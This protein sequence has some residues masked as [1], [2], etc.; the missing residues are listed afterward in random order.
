MRA[1]EPRLLLDAASAETAL[2]VAG[3]AAHEQL[4]DDYIANG[5]PVAATVQQQAER[6]RL[7]MPPNVVEQHAV[8]REAEM[9]ALDKRGNEIVFIDSAVDDIDGL[10]A[11]LEPGASVHILDGNS[12]GL[13]QIAEI[14]AGGGQYDAIHIFSHGDPGALQLGNTIVNAT[15]MV[16]EHADTLSS[17]GQAISENAD[18]L[19]YGCRFGEG[20]LG[21]AAADQLALATGADIA[22]SDDLTGSESLSGDWDLEVH[23]GDVQA[24]SYTLPDWE[25]ILPGFNLGA[26]VEPTY[27]HASGGVVGTAGTIAVW[28]GA[29]TRDPGGGNPIEV[30]DVRAI[31]V[32]TTDKATAT[33]ENV[34]SGDGSL[35]DFRVVVT[36]LGDVTGNVGG[37]DILEEQSVT[38][39]WEVIDSL[40]GNPAPPDM[41]NIVLR[42]IDGLAGQPDTRNQVGIAADSL[43]SYTTESTTDLQISVEDGELIAAGT[44][45]GTNAPNSQ[46]GASWAS[47]N[48]FVVTYTTFEQTANIDLD[49]DGGATFADPV[50]VASQ[51]LDLNGAAAGVNYVTTYYNRAIA[52][53]D[54]DVPVSIAD[55]DISIFDLNNNELTESTITLTNAQPGDVL[56]YDIGVLNALG[57]TATYTDNV[58]NI[59]LQLS[60]FASLDNYE[61]AIRSI[62]Y[63]NGLPDGTGAGTI[64]SGID[65]I[66]SVDI[67]DNFISTTGVQ[68]RIVITDASGAPVTGNNIFVEDE[69][70]VLM[71]NAANGLLS[72]DSDPEGTTLTIL[73]AED[74][75]GDP[76][77]LNTAYT[78]PSGSMLTLAADGSFTYVP[79]THYSGNET[80]RYTV[81][82][83]SNTTEGFATF[84]IQPVA[85]NVTLNI[86]QS[87]PTSD[88]DQ[89]TNPIQVGAF[90]PDSG[91]TQEITVEDIP[92]GVVLTDGVNQHESS[93]LFDFVDVTSWNLNNLH[94]LP[95]QNRDADISVTVIA[96]TIESDGSTSDDI[97]TVTFEID[98]VAD[99]PT[100]IVL[101]G[102][103]GVDDDVALFNL[104]SP[105]LFD[106]DGSEQ[107]T[108]ITISNIPAGGQILVSGTPRT[109][110]GGAVSLQ[111]S[112]LFTAVF[113]PPQTGMA[114][115]YNMLVSATATEVAPEGG[116]NISVLSATE[117][118]IGLRVDLN[119]DDDPVVAVD[120]FATTFSGNTISIDVVANDFAPDGGTLITHING[121]PID[122]PTPYTLP[123]GQGVIRLG[124]SGDLLYEASAAFS[125]TFDFTYTVQDTD[126]DA[127]DGLVTVTVLPRWEI[128]NVPAAQEGGNAEFTVTLQGGLAPGSGAD[129]DIGVQ[130]GTASAADIGSL[131]AAINNAIAQPGNEGFSFD[132]TTL[133]YLA[134][135]MSYSSTYEA[136]GSTFADITG[137]A[138]SLNLGGDGLAS[139]DIP[140]SFDFYGGSFDE[141]YVSANGYITFG[142]PVSEP[143]NQ[144]LDGT[145]LT[146]RSIIAPF[147]DDL[148]TTIGDVYVQS[149]GL[150]VSNRQFIIQW[151]MV[152]NESDGSGVGRFQVVLDE[153]TGSVRFNYADVIFD[154]IGDEGA[155][156]TIGL[157]GDGF[158]DQFS[159][160]QAGSVVDGSSIVF[161]RGVAINPSLTIQLP[162]IDDPAFEPQETFSLV[163]SNPNNAGL[164]ADTANTTID[165][166]DNSPPDAIDD[167]TAVLETSTVSLNVITAGAGDTD[168]EGHT[169]TLTAIDGAALSGPG[170]QFTLASGAI[171]TANPD[172]SVS[173]DPNG[174][175]ISLAGG[176]TASDSFTYE[177]D[178]GFGGTDT[179]TVNVTITGENQAAFV[180][181]N[182]D[183]TTPTVDYAF[184]FQPTD[185][186]I[187]VADPAATIVDPD[188]TEFDS[189][190][191]V[192]S[193]FLQPGNEIVA[194]D[195]FL[196]NFGTARSGTVLIGSTTFAVNYDGVNQI[197]VSNSNPPEIPR[198]D[199]EAMI[200]S[201]TYENDSSD[202]TPGIRTMVFQLDDGDGLGPASTTQ[203]TVIGNNID[204][205]AGD[206]GTGTPFET[207]EET[208]ITI[209]VATLLANDFDP[210]GDG[211][212]V[213]AVDGGANGTAILDGLGNV[214]FT[215]ATDF[216]GL[217]SFTYTLR[218]SRG[219]T[220]TG[221][222]FV[223]VTPINDAPT[224]DLDGGT[225]GLD[226]AFTYTENDPAT[227]IIEASGVL[228]DVDNSQLAS[229]TITL[230]NGQIDDV[231]TVGTLPGGIT[232]TVNPPN[233]ATGLTSAGSV[234]V[235]L[236][237]LA[238]IA[239]YDTALR[240]IGFS[241]AS[242][243]PFAG[244]RTV[245]VTVDDGN[246]SS[247]VA[248][249]TITVVSV[250]DAPVAVDDNYIV[251]ED[252]SR[253]FTTIELTGNDIEPDLDVLTIISADS[254]VNGTVILNGDGTVTFT[255]TGDYFGAAS[256]NY[257]IDDGN[258][259]Q[260]TATVNLTISPVDDPSSLDLDTG[261]AGTNFSTSYVE[262]GPNAQLVDPS[263]SIIDI[264]SST[265]AG[266]TITLTNAQIGDDFIIGTLPGGI[267][268][269][270]TPSGPQISAGTK[271]LSLSGTASVADYQLAL[272]RIFYATASDAP[273]TV[274][275]NVTIT[276]NDGTSNSNVATTTI[277]VSAVNDAPVAAN[278]G[279]FTLDEDT[280]LVLTPAALLFNDND[281]DGDPINLISVQG[282]VGGTV[283]INGGGDVV[284]TP[285][286]ETSGPASFTYT[287][288][289][290]SGVQ[291]TATVSLTI[292]PINDAPTLDADTGTAGAGYATAYTEG[293]VG[294][295][296]VDASVLIGDIDDTQ[297]ESA[298]ITLTNGFAGDILETGT[299]PG[300]ITANIVPPAGLVVNGTI[301]VTLSGS[302]SLADYQTALQAITY[303]SSSQNIDTTA[304]SLSVVVNDG[305]DNSNTA[306]TTI[307]ITAVNDAPVA[308]N[309]GPFTIDE[310][311]PLTLSTASLLFNDSDP[312]GDTLTVISVQGAINGTVTLVSGT[313]T[314]TPTPDYNGP[315]SF[316]YTI[317]DG[318]GETDTGTV[319]IN[320]TSINDLPQV[321]LNGGAAGRDYATSWVE[322]APAVTLLDAAATLTDADN[323]ILSSATF[324]LTN[325]QADDILEFGAL[326]PGITATTNPAS[327][328][329]LPG[330]FT[331]TLS[332]S[333]SQADYLTAL[334]TVT[335]R[336]LSEDPD[337]MTRTISL[338]V[339]DGIGDSA[340]ATTTVAV[341]AVND[342]PVGSADGP[343]STNED[344][345]LAI[346]TAD[347]LSNDSD[348]ENSALSIVSVQ[349]PVNGTVSLSGGTITFT[350]VPNYSGPASFTYT[351]RDAQGATDI[352]VVDINVVSVNDAPVIDLD[353]VAAG[354]GYQ[355]TYTE[356]DP[357]V[358]I[359]STN[360]SVFDVD[361]ANISSA[362]ILLT[363]G[364]T[365][366]Q[367]SVGVLPP[368]ISATIS[369]IAPL[370]G[371]GTVIVTL[372]GASSHADYET[373]LRAITF[374]SVSETPDTVRRVIE[375]SVSDGLT[376]SVVATSNIDVI[377]VNDAPVATN[378]GVPTPLAAVEDTP[379]TF[380]PVSANDSDVDGDTLVITEIDGSSI[381]PGGSVVLANG[382]VSLAAD[383]VTL[384][385]DP[386]LNFN[387]PV[388]FSYTVSDGS[389]TDTALV[390]IDVAAVNDAPVALDDGPVVLLEDGIAFFDPVTA[391]DSDVEG[392]ALTITAIDGQP[393]STG[394]T[395]AVSN[396][397]ISLGSDGRTIRFDP[398]PDFNGPTTITYRVSD[399]QD[400]S[401]AVVSF[402]VTPVDDPVTVATTPPNV[403]FF[404]SDTVNL[405]LAGFFVDPDGDVLTYS[406][407]GLPAGLTI[408]SATGLVSGT[409]GSSAS[410]SGPYPVTVTVD[411]GVASVVSTSFTIDVVNTIPVGVVNQAVSVDDGSALSLDANTLF[412]DADG[413]ALT[414]STSSLPLWLSFN[415]ATGILSG[416]APSDASVTGPFVVT[417][418]A[419]DL[420]GGVANVD[421]TID[422]QN[423]PPVTTR[424]IPDLRVGE[425]EGVE[426]DI[427]GLFVDGGFDSD[428]ITISVAGLPEGITYDPATGIISGTTL[429]GSGSATPYRVEVTA[430]DG[431]GG[432]TTY[433]FGIRI[434]DPGLIEQADPLATGGDTRSDQL[435]EDD[436]DNTAF[437]TDTVADLSS[438]NGIG[439]LPEDGGAILSVVENIQSLQ[440]AT[441]SSVSGS[442]GGLIASL[443]QLS[444]PQ[445]WVS[446]SG[447]IND[448]EWNV[449][450]SHPFAS[451]IDHGPA[452]E[453][454]PGVQPYVD[455]TMP[456]LQLAALR[457]NGIFYLELRNGLNLLRDG[458]L[459]EMDLTL[460][461]GE[462]LPEWIDFV[463]PGFATANP[464]ETV[465]AI[466]I[467]MRAVLDSGTTVEKLIHIDFA[468]LRD[469]EVSGG[470]ST[471]P[472]S[473]PAKAGDSLVEPVRFA[474]Q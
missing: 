209:P 285:T 263:V 205:V 34:A 104:I 322:N 175:F 246:L 320:V 306:T 7:A 33:F 212:D 130:F 252:T 362:S 23:S 428:P 15:T 419:D 347:L 438:L 327:A 51:S 424:E 321:D 183:G 118:N 313:I 47:A 413:D 194:I 225:A 162:V 342:A 258:G 461:D 154:G 435:E 381:L 138:P 334:R 62:T 453:P 190:L 281:P 45:D 103:G 261:T 383:G 408:D 6:E 316:T 380:D 460:S 402:D 421:V 332:G 459:I 177:I 181:L 309:D 301:T 376:S 191:I 143:D 178:D 53:S 290:T 264:D 467:R 94:I 180:D 456:L 353:T 335:Y 203:I 206:D 119:D 85:D 236:S 393:I 192:L 204:P 92:A 176:A 315:A 439:E 343:F 241:V 157:Q 120:D 361:H 57:V 211:I 389:L 52:G 215:P 330:T 268:A 311:T 465:D 411:D 145:A 443:G 49:G 249:T 39:L 44:L 36:S 336:N 388:N 266:A 231:I 470:Q 390:S 239:D 319:N 472:E 24:R 369:P 358:E 279:P 289:D 80:I 431:Q 378:D 66:V 125:G 14:V 146:S 346:A 30:Y 416:T 297:I 295:P 418:T 412:S 63:S 238:S 354:A 356:N 2:D 232:A 58:T 436:D 324:V 137:T 318:N 70:T 161:S 464:P 352:V 427:N 291:S 31:I 351:V 121:V 394:G 41:V 126:L 430:D 210:D 224:V 132:G 140:F 287:I 250:N 463:C 169:L 220:D 384:T 445:G 240:A 245:T 68:T 64:Q 164:G 37:Q 78:M 364:Q 242:D 420:E 89:P 451:I 222:V 124:L 284:F 373:A 134:P 244:D 355:T 159:F 156:A 219:G 317:D 452:T 200:R 99:T 9:A 217:T 410:Q 275:R 437:I 123:G 150:G 405:P 267:S 296:I 27:T 357:G 283:I 468:V 274:N 254:A 407:A 174:V 42:D 367:I 426:I 397:S 105:Q 129:I 273:S 29:A 234:T 323:A 50:T 1:L 38:V 325:G 147:W 193:G 32:G 182:D 227:S 243:R 304:R 368:G 363:N 167:S 3:K 341:T 446:Q 142:T 172:G 101:E 116:G 87:D 312:E 22:A 25:G 434:G 13:N 26:V 447:W 82:D 253:T 331:L 151:D 235:A 111:M 96:T 114:A 401:S 277:A 187:A 158:G 455:E 425:E 86:V 21:R 457:R 403:S 155:G 415:P 131:T 79:D 139:V 197:T 307:A 348:P 144:M 4:A 340:V 406:A 216:N 269:F 84:S 10:I 314:F 115:V 448:G 247:A 280:Q 262:D 55:I 474:P 107:I 195:T 8:E 133:S 370:T 366:D 98:A 221:Q 71:V 255:P 173:Y 148:G 414:F 166:S 365:G 81:S 256:F 17:I 40:S 202:D 449:E 91:E 199:V 433:S 293:G 207:Q 83:G 168:A 375:I 344:T 60:G 372:S 35:A 302:A 160:N 208:A 286:P 11:S 395:L 282:A 392:D 288:E 61:T 400:T 100:L 299:L 233:A 382:S 43:S 270:E 127:D 329:A 153:G 379:F 230:Q 260:S 432:V 360:L 371:S 350:P 201:I 135:P 257:T 337:T 248:T 12:D 165:I 229:A 74:W 326:P 196:L 59:V 423:P 441:G 184:D 185:G 113:R 16:G 473:S 471:V 76:I 271:T 198:A 374:S 75:Q 422:P 141:L 73:S 450:T 429:D 338:T 298:T 328:L 19:L 278:D 440:Q 20:E 128:S 65:R 237:G 333:A 122:V 18:I 171:V 444:E 5:R 56:N 458:K 152:N 292:L 387:G 108:D 462:P 97:R 95:L 359:V 310:D 77:P 90:S 294:L 303:R 46:I 228:A 109:I 409:L 385:F 305:S 72:D 106:T 223:N 300:G 186:P 276:V 218:D 179:A 272:T 28:T 69:D 226:Y 339:N 454:P 214:I 67:A 469:A 188:D 349:G 93:G 442:D 189:L 308:A 417:I 117:A 404:D 345:V 391:N 265:L 149:Q 102:T 251:T 170:S 54:N 48:R 88:E 377:S 112:D 136:A 396:G 163:L 466:D 399:G 110:T 259:E 398:D 213:F 386:R